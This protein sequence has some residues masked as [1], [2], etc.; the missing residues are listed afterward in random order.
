MPQTNP[1]WRRRAMD[2]WTDG[3][4][5]GAIAVLLERS[6]EEVT[7]MLSAHVPGASEQLDRAPDRASATWSLSGDG[8][9]TATLPD[10]AEAALLQGGRAADM[11]LGYVRGETLQEIGDRWGVSRERV[12][13]VLANESPW[14]S[15]TIGTA[16]RAFLAEEK[17]IAT[18]AVLAWS[19]AHP[20][21]PIDEAAEHLDLPPG[22]VRALLGR[23][24]RLHEGI[25]PHGG[26][27]RRSEDE[28]LDDLRR[29]HEET[30]GGSALTYSAWASRHSLPGHQTIMQRFGSWRAALQRAG[31]GQEAPIAR[32]RQHSEEDLWAA[33]VDA[34]RMG[35]ATAAEVDHWLATTNGAPSFAL[36]R[37]RLEQ[38]WSELHSVALHLL[39]G[40]YAH[41]PAW[42]AEVLRPRRWADLCVPGQKEGPVECIAAA[43][44]DLGPGITL[45]SY[46]EWAAQN[47]RP[48]AATVTRRAGTS[49][50]QLVIAAGGR[51]MAKPKWTSESAIVGQLLTFLDTYP[52]GTIEEYKRWRS[53]RAAPSVSTIASRFGGWPQAKAH[54]L[55]ARRGQES[56]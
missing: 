1:V 31:I 46:R 21:H 24:R 20:G 19:H 34:V 27:R 48:T 39:R 49:W 8:A 44:A 15:G 43:I 13:Q 56:T 50:S 17:S 53:S 28:L 3:H 38:P 10:I 55:D 30:G 33:V 52:E 9:S 32:Q 47:G 25:R 40:T 4:T 35:H 54:A 12:R 7:E 29:F 45:D 14:D 51:S 41:D 5:V 36:I 6:D 26:Q 37:A 42:A 18:S 16:R 11:V 2:L 22:D 23:R